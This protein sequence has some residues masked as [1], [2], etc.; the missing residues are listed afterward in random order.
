MSW[1]DFK[2]DNLMK[3]KIVGVSAV[4]VFKKNVSPLEILDFLHSKSR[5]NIHEIREGVSKDFSNVS[6]S[7]TGQRDFHRVDFHHK[8][9]NR[10]LSVF[11]NGNC[12]CDYKDLTDDDVTLVTMGSYGTST[13][14]LMLLLENLGGGWIDENDWIEVKPS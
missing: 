5:R 13:E 8:D 6:V 2:L 1:V 11:H 12:K 9:V 3:G 4:A 14:I 7:S 10:S